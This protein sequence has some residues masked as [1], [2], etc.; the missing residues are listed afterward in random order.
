MWYSTSNLGWTFSPPFRSFSDTYHVTWFMCTLSKLYYTENGVAQEFKW[1]LS[2]MLGS[3]L[4]TNFGDGCWWQENFSGQRS[5]TYWIIFVT[6][7]FTCNKAQSIIGCQQRRC[8]S[9]YGIMIDLEL[10]SF[11][12]HTTC[13]WTRGKKW[14]VRTLNIPIQITRRVTYM[15]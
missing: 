13:L 1:G 5:M 14:F 8:I 10:V 9:R 4:V 11:H 7:R 6:T 3:Q 12:D 15:I 2:L